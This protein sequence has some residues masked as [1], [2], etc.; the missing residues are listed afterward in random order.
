VIADL[1]RS[2]VV[3]AWAQTRKIDLEFPEDRIRPPLTDA[4]RAEYWPEGAEA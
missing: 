4:E 1:A 3:D 2:I